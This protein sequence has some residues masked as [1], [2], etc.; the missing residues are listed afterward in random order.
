M[1]DAGC[2]PLDAGNAVGRTSG[3]SSFRGLM[4][5]IHRLSFLPQGGLTAATNP[6]KAGFTQ[7]H[8]DTK[9][10]FIQRLLPNNGRRPSRA[11]CVLILSLSCRI[12]TNPSRCLRVLCAVHQNFSARCGEVTDKGS[13]GQPPG[14]WVAGSVSPL[15]IKPVHTFGLCQSVP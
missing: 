5:R 6:A 14:C 12:R 8:Q 13:K 1:V 15:L 10:S 9:L 3:R 7:S 11:W 4:D 2:W